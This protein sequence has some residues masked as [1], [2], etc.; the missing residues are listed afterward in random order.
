MPLTRSLE[1]KHA[2]I[3]GKRVGV[4]IARFETGQPFSDFTPQTLTVAA[5]G[6]AKGAT[7]V[8]LASALTK[9]VNKGQFLC[10]ADINDIEH[11]VE[12]TAKAATG[13][14]AL[15]CRALDEAITAAETAEYPAY[16]WD[17]TEAGIDQSIA[18]DTVE[19]FNT[20]GNEDG[21]PGTKSGS[22][23]TPG[24]KYHYNAASQTLARAV[25]D[26]A[27]VIVRR[28]E[29]VPS[30]AFTTGEVTVFRAGV[31]SKASAAPASGALT[32]DYT[33]KILGAVQTTLPVPVA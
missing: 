33:L 26:S 20:G 16:L 7:S 10:F 25:S 5:G 14:T 13:A 18:Y 8:P 21:T 30:P 19:T 2:P 24:L 32:D 9:P 27:F 28:E 11:L 1:Q 15:T 3:Q 23:S 31:E 22:L 17:R 6:A 29:P 12:V 4:Y